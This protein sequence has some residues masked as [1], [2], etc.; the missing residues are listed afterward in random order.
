MEDFYRSDFGFL[1]G[2]KLEHTEMA[3]ETGKLF[4]YSIEIESLKE[5]GEEKGLSSREKKRLNFLKKKC[6][7]LNK[8][9]IC[10]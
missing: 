7:S 2:A 3:W 1:P 9:G 8:K 6:E 4:H 10:A 5:K